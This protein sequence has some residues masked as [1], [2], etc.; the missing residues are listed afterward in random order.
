MFDEKRAMERIVKKSF[1]GS[2]LFACA[3]LMAGTGMA[4]AQTAGAPDTIFVNG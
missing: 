3:L 2:T 1:L 4:T